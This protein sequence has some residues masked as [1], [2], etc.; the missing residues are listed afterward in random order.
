[1]GIHFGAAAVTL[2]SDA[3]ASIRRV[4]I[5][6]RASVRRLGLQR[7]FSIFPGGWPGVGLLLLRAAAGVT[8]VVGGGVHLSDHGASTPGTWIV[9]LP[10]VACGA[11][12]LVGFL[13]PVVG[14][15]VGLGTIAVALS[16][17][18]AANSNA[19]DARLSLTLLV[20]MDAAIVLLGPGAFSL[21]A[22]LFGRREIIIP[23]AP[24]PT[25]S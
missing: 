19:F 6:R 11:L 14:A 15:T 24:R 12:L 23:Q 8:A 5:T 20:V 1:V 10:A 16:W 22:R 3:S 9:G 25:K 17:L 18:P 7:L 21:D 2:R 4:C 13:T